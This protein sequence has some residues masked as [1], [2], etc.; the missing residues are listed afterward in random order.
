LTL[1]QK[2]LGS[3]EVYPQSLLHSPNGRFV[4]VCGDGEYIIYTA[5]AWR[6]KAFGSALDFVWGSKDNSNDYAIRESTTSVRIYRNFK[7]KGNGL[8]VGFQ[9]EGLFGGVLLAVRG[10]SGVGLFDWETGGLVRRID[11]EPRSVSIAALP[12]ISNVLTL[13]AH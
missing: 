6:N 10:S 4:S 8:D 3:C 1:Q 9:A 2:A 13:V 11:V 7:E 12:N 5:L